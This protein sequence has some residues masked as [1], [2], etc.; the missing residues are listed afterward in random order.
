M[1]RIK[2]PPSVCKEKNPPT[3]Y[4][5]GQDN[6]NWVGSYLRP[7]RRD[8]SKYHNKTTPYRHEAYDVRS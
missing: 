1:E 8:M 3:P 5:F 7:I 2:E 6:S 4:W